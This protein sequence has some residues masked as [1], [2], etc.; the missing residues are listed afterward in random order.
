MDSIG[1]V[2]ISNPWKPISSRI[3]FDKIIELLT[4]LLALL[5]PR[6]GS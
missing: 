1:T 3:N 2:A 4:P 6:T 5:D